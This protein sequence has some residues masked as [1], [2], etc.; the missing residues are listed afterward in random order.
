M[1]R[2][3]L[4]R[5]GGN[6]LK[7]GF[8]LFSWIATMWEGSIQFKTP[9]LFATGFILLFTIGGLTGILLSNGALDFALHDTYYVVGHFHYGA[10]SNFI[11]RCLS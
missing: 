4:V 11:S 9:M 8:T 7:M 2:N 6:S 3:M 5:F 1:H 10:P